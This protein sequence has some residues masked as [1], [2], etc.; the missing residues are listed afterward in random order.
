M[1]A[2]TAIELLV[3]RVLYRTLARIR[4]I[5]SGGASPETST[6]HC[7]PATR[8]PLEIVEII[9]AYLRYDTRSLRACTLTCYSWYIAAVPHLHHILTIKYG[10][11]WVGWKFRWPNPIQHMHV[12]GLLPLVQEFR[13]NERYDGLSSKSF[14]SRILRQFSAL[15]NVQKLEIESLDIPSFMPRIRRYFGHFLPTVRSLTLRKPKGSHRQIIYFIGLFQH[16]QD[17]ELNDEDR[18]GS[19]SE[20]AGNSMLIPTFIPPLRGRLGLSSFNRTGFFEDMIE[21]FGGIRF[22]YMYLSRVR[23]ARPLLDACAKTL[24]DLV[25]NATGHLGEQLPLRGMRV[26][27]N[28]LAAGY[29]LRD[30]D[31]SQD[32]S[33]RTLKVIMSLP[34]NRPSSDGLP[35]TTSR[36]LNRLLSTVTSSAFLEITVSYGSYHFDYVDRNRELSQAERAEEVSWH[37]EIFKVFREAHKV[38]DFRLCA[39]FC[40]FVGEDPMRILGE[41][42][43]EERT[44]GG[45]ND[46]LYDPFVYNLYKPPF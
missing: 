20:P 13:V 2:T 22:R 32:K 41:A 5:T 42:M 31:L 30:F 16:L 36:V 26:I 6:A 11:L 25:L 45:F 46:F 3:K 23:G 29:S 37:R 44:E 17:L 28:D 35:E 1:V 43:D 8:L 33:L 15:T 24:E 4:K 34:I 39:I 19:L 10:Y 14:N 21:L 18:S 9:I 40:G 38:R 12:L 27:A 7:S